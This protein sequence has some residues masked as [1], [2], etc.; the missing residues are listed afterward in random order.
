M[1]C[2]HKCL[3]STRVQCPWRPEMGIGSSGTGV[4]DGC[5][6]SGW[7]LSLGSLE[8]QSVILSNEPSLQPLLL[9]RNRKFLR[10]FLKKKSWE[11]TWV[12][13]CPEATP[14]FIPVWGKPLLSFSIS[15]STVLGPSLNFLFLFLKVYIFL[16]LSAP[17]ALFHC[18]SE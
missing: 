18:R 14:P 17:F 15:V 1:F 2:L 16:L 5:D 4:A 10:P 3:C 13:P 9:F 12:G 6:L 8:E 11:P 7:E